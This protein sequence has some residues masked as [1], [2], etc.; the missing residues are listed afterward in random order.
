MS[1]FINISL[2]FNPDIGGAIYFIPLLVC[3]FGKLFGKSFLALLIDI[4]SCASEFYMVNIAWWE[5]NSGLYKWQ[6]A[7]SP[8]KIAWTLSAN[9]EP[10]LN[11]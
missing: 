2:H 10:G 3:R 9:D 1:R 7:T 5:Q 4:G 11:A 8:A 6:M